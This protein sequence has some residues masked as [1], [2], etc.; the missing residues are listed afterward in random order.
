MEYPDRYDPVHCTCGDECDRAEWVYLGSYR[1][2]D[3]PKECG[4]QWQ[5]SS[6]LSALNQ[7]LPG[8]LLSDQMEIE[9][10]NCG[11]E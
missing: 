1:P 9:G 10:E 3:D 11:T 4:W 2:G 6:C 7:A 5:C 8:D